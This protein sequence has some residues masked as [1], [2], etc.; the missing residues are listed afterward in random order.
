MDDQLKIL[1][2]DDSALYRQLVKNVLRDIPGVE[3]VGAAKSGTEALS[4]VAELDPDV[5]TLDVRMP[6]IDGIEVLR[7]LKRNKSRAKAVMLSS[8]T[9]NG[10]QTTTD[11]LFEGAFDFVH[12]PSGSDAIANRMVLLEE[13]TEK[14]QTF[15]SSPEF[16]GFRSPTPSVRTSPARTTEDL[17][18]R[19]DLAVP[20]CSA[21]VIGTSTGGPVALR[22][23]LPELPSNLPV[24]VLIVQHMPPNYTH[25]LAQ[26][27][28]EA[29]SLE[30]IEAVDGMPVEAGH[31]Y[32]APG[33]RHMR[34]ERAGTKIVIRIADDPP[35]LGC[36]PS[37][38]YLLRSAVSV[39]G[40]KLLAV[41]LTGMGRD[42]TEGCREVKRR[43]GTVITQ[44]ADGC[45]VYGMPKAVVDE[46]LSDRVVPLD[47]IGATVTRHVKRSREG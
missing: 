39:Y 11:A 37:V 40:G 17:E 35:E 28:N 41:I 18:T 29:S 47:R 43:G 16:R 15:R 33:G 5:L 1:V 30:V 24:P 3:V 25:S 2:V 14:L 20:R 38:D 10:A 12:K 36:R 27:L 7:T 31:A 6:D 46:Q 23:V 26:R 4:M 42:G 32:I 22:E 45:T 13:L 19:T 21:V 34:V 8:L 9:A 44:H